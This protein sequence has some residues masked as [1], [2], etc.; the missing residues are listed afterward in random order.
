MNEPHQIV[1]TAS[2]TEKSTLMSEKLNK[3]V[4]RV[5]PKANKVQIKNAIERLFQK[6]V[7]HVNTCNYTGKE[8]RV[9]GQS[10]GPWDAVRDGKKRS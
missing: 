6:T 4:F 9:R 5:S 7:V 2:L 1:Q 3:Y 10:V 8:R